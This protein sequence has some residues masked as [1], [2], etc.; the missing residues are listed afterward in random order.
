MAITSNT[1]RPS[2]DFELCLFCGR[3][4]DA[5]RIRVWPGWLP[6]FLRDV[7][8]EEGEVYPVSI[9]IEE[10]DRK[11]KASGATYEYN[12]SPIKGFELV[13]KGASATVMAHWLAQ[14]ISSG[15]RDVV[16]S[17]RHEETSNDSGMTG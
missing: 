10:L 3:E 4:G 5:W 17:N 15:R 16:D 1:P 14:S 6:P 7:F 12:E 8:D 13:A 9:D 2:Q 11:M